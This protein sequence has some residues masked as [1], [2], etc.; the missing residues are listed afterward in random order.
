MS[1]AG[2]LM[3]VTGSREGPGQ[4]PWGVQESYL[5]SLLAYTGVVAALLARREAPARPAWLD[6]S[7]QEGALQ[8]LEC[9]FVSESYLGVTRARRDGTNPF[10]YPYELYPCKDGYVLAAIG[11][12]W[13]YF[14]ET[15]NEPGLDDPAFA[16]LEDRMRNRPRLDELLTR[17]FAPF[18][19]DELLAIGQA[20]RCPFG[21]AYRPSQ[22][23]ES[24]HWRERGTFARVISGAREATVPVSGLGARFHAESAAPRSAAATAGQTVALPGFTIHATQRLEQG[25][26]IRWHGRS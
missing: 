14:A 11:H 18:T 15:L 23:L 7:V 20:V 9:A 24:E 16:T 17:G 26:V 6:V 4:R 25:G 3:S 1:A 8:A 12:D 13:P 22:V 5:A 2:G 10:G 19:P 21:A